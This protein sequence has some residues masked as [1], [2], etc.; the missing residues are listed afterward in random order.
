MAAEDLKLLDSLVS[1][2]QDIKPYH[3]KLRAFTSELQ[4]NDELVIGI[5]DDVSTTTALTNLWD[6]SAFGVIDTLAS[7]SGGTDADRYFKLPFAIY[8]RFSLNDHSDQYPSGDD[9]A[10]LSFTDGNS[11]EI[12]DE[13]QPWTGARSPSHQTG[14]ADEVAYEYPV[15]TQAI[16]I[17][18]ATLASGSYT[19][20]TYS[21]SYTLDFSIDATD[22]TVYGLSSSTI[23]IYI[24]DAQYVGSYYRSGSN[25]TITGLVGTF[26]F[27]SAD[28]VNVPSPTAGNVTDTARYGALRRSPKVRLYA[29]TGTG[30]Y[31]VPNH[32]GARVYVN[33]ALKDYGVHYVTEQPRN[34]IQFL[35]GNHPA[36]GAHLNFQLMTVD[37]V[38]IAYNDRFDWGVLRGYDED[39]WS[40][41]NFDSSLGDADTFT[42]TINHAAPNGY[43]P[44]EFHN[45]NPVYANKPPLTMLN[46]NLSN[47]ATG[48]VWEVKAFSYFGFT[49]RQISPTIGPSQVAYFKTTFTNDSISF[50]ID[51][52][53]STYS[54]TADSN[55]Y[56]TLGAGTPSDPTDFQV[57]LLTA[58]EHGALIDPS[59]TIH[60][61]VELTPFGVIKRR[62]IDGKSEYYFVLDSIPRVGTYIEFRVDEND[63]FNP[64]A[65][66]AITDQVTI[67]SY[68]VDGIGTT[69]IHA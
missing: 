37:Q 29:T 51:R 23:G 69:E 12:P 6:R 7:L 4:V 49:V 9:P 65:G 50:I 2:L 26:D 15:T 38:F 41:V 59:P 5:T 47:T 55:T 43:D 54:I 52:F 35:A 8:P 3:T 14:V 1:Y 62:E 57:N 39:P 34:V 63:Q 17:T 33:G 42:I 10:T 22:E 58:T 24:D 68:A 30:R 11:D 18:S 64:R 48:D 40:V 25:F 45:A 61:P 16:T 28:L 27:T 20:G 67:L 31:A 32:M 53:W 13:D 36:S 60:K 19:S 21:Y 56:T 46:V 66:I 44:V